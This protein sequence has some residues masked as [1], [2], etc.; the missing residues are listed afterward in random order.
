MERKLRFVIECVVPPFS[1]ESCACLLMGAFT[2]R[3]KYLGTIEV[4][5]PLLSYTHAHAGS[6]LDERASTWCESQ[7]DNN[8][9]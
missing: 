5:I 9:D 3:G 4:E 6:E 7:D 1:C 8:G 2:R